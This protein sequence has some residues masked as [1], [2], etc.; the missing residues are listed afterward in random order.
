VRFEGGGRWI[1]ALFLPEAMPIP[2]T[3]TAG[4]P[5]NDAVARRDRQFALREL[6]GYALAFG[7]LA[8]AFLVTRVTWPL[9]SGTPLILLFGATFAAARWA[10]ETPAILSILLAAFAA[11]RVAPPGS[12]FTI[13]ESSIVVFAAGSLVISRIV[14]GRNRVEAALRASEGQFRAAWDNSAFGA[15]LLNRRGMVERINPAMERTLGY[16]SAAWAGVSFGYFGDPMHASSDRSRFIDF[17]NGTDE[18]YQDEQRY[19]RADGT[20]IWCRVT[21]SAVQDVAGGRRTGA[22]MVL[23]D[24]TRRRKAESDLREWEARY[25]SL[26]EQVPIGLFQSGADGRFVA[27]NARLLGMLG[28]DAWSSLSGAGIADFLIERD[29]RSTVQDAMA[30]GQEVEDL[31][32]SL[33]RKDGSRAGVV[34]DV[35]PVRG[36]EGAVVYYDGIVRET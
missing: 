10:G 17:V 12:G 35:R 26:F 23:E 27:V 30:D 33:Q 25:L 19:R 4:T 1:V 34:M 18:W 5:A 31:V 7:A 28:Y 36:P 11:T 3:W 21:M 32:T 15:A 6:R 8:A 29:A 9:F 13:D 20:I 2:L 14:A 16:P 24:V 22:L